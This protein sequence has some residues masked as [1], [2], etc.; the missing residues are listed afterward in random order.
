M[1]LIPELIKATFFDRPPMKVADEIEM[2]EVTNIR[3]MTVRKPVLPL[4]LTMCI[5][6][7][8]KLLPVRILILP[9]Y[10]HPKYFLNFVDILGFEEAK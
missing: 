1:H 8:M 4:N 7:I 9:F 5:W 6:L 3:D 10:S 2:A